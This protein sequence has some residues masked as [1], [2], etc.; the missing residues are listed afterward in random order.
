MHPC[1]KEEEEEETS[2]CSKVGYDEGIRSSGVEFP[3]KGDG[4]TWI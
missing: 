2:L 1:N 4:E 3:G